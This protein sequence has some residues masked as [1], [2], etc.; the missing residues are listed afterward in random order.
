MYFLESLNKG[1][2][3]LV[4]VS[5]TYSATETSTGVPSYEMAF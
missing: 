3:A 2:K 1:Y 5:V 4:T